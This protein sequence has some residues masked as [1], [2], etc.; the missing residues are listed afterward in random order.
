[1]EQ[2][3]ESLQDSQDLREGGRE[4][5]RQ[6]GREGGMSGRDHGAKRGEGEK[7]G[8]GEGGRPDVPAHWYLQPGAPLEKVGVVVQVALKLPDFL[9]V[10]AEDGFLALL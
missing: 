9:L 10:V 4:R 2:G 8:G 5:G 7:E 3:S 1:M 6:G